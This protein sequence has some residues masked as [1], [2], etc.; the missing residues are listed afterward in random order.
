MSRKLKRMVKCLIAFS[1]IFTIVG[2]KSTKSEDEMNKIFKEEDLTIYEEPY[3]EEPNIYISFETHKDWV[4]YDKDGIKYESRDMNKYKLV[5]KLT[6]KQ[7]TKYNK[8]F[9]SYEF[10]Q[11]DLESYM[12]NRFE[13]VTNK[14]NKLSYK[15][16]FIYTWKNGYLDDDEI[17]EGKEFLNNLSKADIK[18]LYKLFLK[19]EG[20]IDFG[21]DTTKEEYYKEI[22]A[23]RDIKNAIDNLDYVLYDNVDSP[24]FDFDSIVKNDNETTLYYTINP[25]TKSISGKYAFTYNDNNEIVSVALLFDS[26]SSGDVAC[27]YAGYLVTA[28]ESDVDEEYD[29]TVVAINSYNTVYEKNGFSHSLVLTGDTDGFLMKPLN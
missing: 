5:D 21:V 3:D 27:I 16:K 12:K 25:S 24:N 11:D 17:E 14:Y 18:K 28:C 19:E 10:T 26:Y 8:I 20:T 2:C 29:G 4:R 9:D 22:D 7:K 1:F 15:D 13:K 6:D 23:P